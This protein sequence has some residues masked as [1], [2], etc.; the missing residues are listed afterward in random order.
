MSYSDFECWR[1]DQYQELPQ[2]R[3]ENVPNPLGAEKQEYT[4]LDGMQKDK[5]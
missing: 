2:R 1:L 3:R 4:D 5:K